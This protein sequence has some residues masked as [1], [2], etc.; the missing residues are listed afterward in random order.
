[1]SKHHSPEYPNGPS[2]ISPA[3]ALPDVVERLVTR[4]QITSEDGDVLIIRERVLR[5]SEAEHLASTRNT[6][7]VCI[8]DDGTRGLSSVKA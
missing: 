2:R 1:V 3:D 4:R 5:L 6:R 8:E 7:V